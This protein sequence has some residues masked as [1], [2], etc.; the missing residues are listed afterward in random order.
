ML[1]LMATRNPAIFHQLRLVVTIYH[2]LQGFLY[3]QRVVFASP[4]AINVVS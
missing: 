2:Y 4:D 1:L 3:I